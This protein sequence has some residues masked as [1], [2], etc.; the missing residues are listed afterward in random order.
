[1]SG[2]WAPIIWMAAMAV[3]GGSILLLDELGKRQRAKKHRRPPV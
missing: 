3:F 1:M 2:Q